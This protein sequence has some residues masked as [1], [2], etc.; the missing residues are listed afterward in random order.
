MSLNFGPQWMRKIPANGAGDHPPGTA[1]APAPAATSASAAGPAPAKSAWASGRPNLNAPLPAPIGASAPAPAAAATSAS[2]TS[3]SAAASATTPAKPSSGSA[4]S[5]A[6]VTQHTPTKAPNTNAATPASNSNSASNRSGAARPSNRDSRDTNSQSTEPHLHAL[7][8]NPTAAHAKG[9]AAASVSDDVRAATASAPAS[10]LPAANAI[11][12]PFKYSRDFLLSLFSPDCPLPAVFDTSLGSYNAIAREPLANLPLSE[13]EKRLLMQANINSDTR[14]AVHRPEGS[15]N[16]RT[17][18]AESRGGQPRAPGDRS[19]TKRDMPLTT[20]TEATNPDDLWDTPKALGTFSGGVFGDLDNRLT[21]P[22]GGDSGRRGD[23]DFGKIGFGGGDG[24]RQQHGHGHNVSRQASDIADAAAFRGGLGRGKFDDPSLSL[25]GSRQPSFPDTFDGFVTRPGGGGLDFEARREP[26]G[27]DFGFGGGGAPAGLSGGALGATGLGVATGGPSFAQQMHAR[28]GLPHSL[29]PGQ[30]IGVGGMDM[31]GSPNAMT[32]GMLNIPPFQFIPPQ[33]VYKDPS[34]AVQGPF[35]SEQMHNWYR[36]GYFPTN[37]PIK[38]VDDQSYIALHQFVERY[39]TQAPFIE[40]LVEQEQLERMFYMRQVQAI[41]R[42]LM[43]L[44]EH[45]FPGGVGIGVGGGLGLQQFGQPPLGGAAGSPTQIDLMDDAALYHHPELSHMPHPQR[46]AHIQ[47][48]RQASALQ[49]Q[50]QREMHFQ[51]QQQQQQQQ[52]QQLQQQILAGGLD[53]SLLAETVSNVPGSVVDPPAHQPS[54][55]SSPS[56]RHRSPSPSGKPPARL[57]SPSTIAPLPVP[58]P[59]EPRAPSPTR[60][61]SPARAK[62]PVREAAAAVAESKQEKQEQQE[63][64]QEQPPRP[65]S[66]AKSVDETTAASASTKQSKRAA[67]GKTGAAAAEETAKTTTPAAST[68]ANNKKKGGKQTDADAVDKLAAKTESL[69]IA[70]SSGSGKGGQQIESPSPAKAAASTA[71]PWAVRAEVAPVVASKPSLKEIQDLEYKAAEERRRKKEKEAQQRLIAEAQLIQ[72]QEQAAATSAIPQASWASNAGPW[73]A[74]AGASGPVAAGGAVPASVASVGAGLPAAAGKKTLAEIM[75]DEA[76]RKRA[77]EQARK[78]TEAASLAGK[79]YADS[80]GSSGSG[81]AIPSLGSG[82][83]ASA[84]AAG[85]GPASAKAAPSVLATG[86][87]LKPVLVPSTT[88]A[89]A[90]GAETEAAGWNVVGKTAQTAARAAATRGSATPSP[91]LTRTASSSGV[92]V[93]GGASAVP[94]AAASPFPGVSMPF[95]Q[96]CR[97][98]L[99]GVQKTLPNFTVDDFLGILFS[100]SVRE[101]ATITMIC[102]DTLGGSTAIDPRK[103][104][105]EFL[106]RRRADQ[107]GA[108]GPG[109]AWSAVS[110]PAAPAAP[111][112]ASIGSV[113]AAAAAANAPEPGWSKV[114]AAKAASPGVVDGEGLALFADDNKFVIRGGAGGKKKKNK[115]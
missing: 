5:F 20:P 103:F 64:Q 18:G 107:P 99:R 82:T 115:K 69:T 55:R 51:M 3:A 86:P 81:P 13:Q 113:A 85:A 74:A 67:K 112:T 26:S 33:W 7:P 46:V 40:S 62:S 1:P 57:P 52:Q 65:A 101:A 9:P 28:Q 87:V 29:L 56:P 84:G 97:G 111:V 100:I 95:V 36:D 114:P 17:P 54:G 110:A 98:A 10:A 30:G 19:A 104:A 15:K 73:K 68:A 102:D 42:R 45:G 39:G 91:A 79:R 16:P 63:K 77:E 35:T 83:W 53:A 38:C 60:S 32:P 58:D 22:I 88:A 49:Q 72:Q 76:K 11:P 75:E 61:Q 70:P 6:S 66:P 34:D 105:D 93:S 41:Q 78:K 24:Q 25:A 31:F 37:L 96:W 90:G 43:G 47:Y 14:R 23:L 50:Q 106:R 48:L 108:S 92:S 109:A 44:P 12:N 94:S 80:I 8:T 59:V 4:L 89:T 71:A 21:D 2:A 27:T